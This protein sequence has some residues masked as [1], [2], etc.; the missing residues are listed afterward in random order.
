MDYLVILLLS[1]FDMSLMSQVEAI[2]FVASKPL[3]PAAI[4]K[5][6]QVEVETVRDALSQLADRYGDPD[7]G[8]SL[9]D[10][11]AEVQLTTRAEHTEIVE[12]YTTQEI[13]GELTRAQLETLTVVAYQ[14]PITRPEL[15]TIRGVNCSIIL[16]NLLVRG[17]VEEDESTDKLMTAYRVSVDALRH[18]GV[19]SVTDLPDYAT[20]HQ[21]PHLSGNSVVEPAVMETE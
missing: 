3:T 12:R 5:S 8:L 4:A 6:L 2:L 1:E 18:L 21:H 13:M 10:T 19:A 15:E 11:G 9:V 20:L 14:G 7:S 16:R 17:L